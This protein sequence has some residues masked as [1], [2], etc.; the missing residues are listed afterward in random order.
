MASL[1]LSLS[2]PWSAPSDVAGM[3][4]NLQGAAP[5]ALGFPDKA[6]AH[7]ATSGAVFKKAPKLKV[8]KTVTK[9]GTP[10]TYTYALVH[11][12][13][14]ALSELHFSRGIGI[15]CCK[16]QYCHVQLLVFF[17]W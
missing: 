3:R 2:L 15:Q 9:L 16:P 11:E 8:G 14:V 7:V 10:S 17:S 6:T 5:Y 4:I 12:G 13:G 1:S